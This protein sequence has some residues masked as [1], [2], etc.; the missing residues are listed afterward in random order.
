MAPINRTPERYRRPYSYLLLGH[1]RLLSPGLYTHNW[2][3]SLH[4]SSYVTSLLA[5]L[6]GHTN[7]LSLGANVLLG[8]SLVGGASLFL[9]I[10]R[11]QEALLI[12]PP[13]PPPQ[14]FRRDDHQ[15][16]PTRASLFLSCCTTAPFPEFLK[17]CRHTGCNSA[18]PR[19]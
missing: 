9:S 17:T 5:V 8:T 13:P 15:N 11:L 18:V 1:Y 6:L 10:L 7:S 19:H 16:A 14:F 12:P 3:D 2:E 4:Y